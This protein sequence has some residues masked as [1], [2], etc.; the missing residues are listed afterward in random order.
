MS[1][2][3]NNC[4]SHLWPKRRSLKLIVG[5]IEKN[6]TGPVIPVILSAG[7]SSHIAWVGVVPGPTNGPFCR[8][9]C[10][11]LPFSIVGRRWF[12]LPKGLS[13]TLCKRPTRWMTR[14][15]S[16]HERPESLSSKCRTYV[17]AW[18]YIMSKNCHHV[19][20]YAHVMPYHPIM[21]GTRCQ[22]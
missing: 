13:D 11:I 4:C 3:K 17:L 9:A 20:T 15:V 6:N 5:C 2:N 22:L 14:W 10:G 18:L 8:V 16:L 7:K 19:G 21:G 1:P 12:S